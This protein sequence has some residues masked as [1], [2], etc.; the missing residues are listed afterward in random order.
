L[1][2]KSIYYSLV[3][4]YFK[5]DSFIHPIRYAYQLHW[6]KKTGAFGHDYTSK[7]IHS[8]NQKINTTTSEILDV[9]KNTS[10]SLELP[11]F[12]A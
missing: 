10:F 9:S 1:A 7:I 8:L 6:F 5:A 11:M 2:Y 3:A 4:K 12:S